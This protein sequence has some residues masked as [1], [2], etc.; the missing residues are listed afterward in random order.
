MEKFAHD[1]DDGLEGFFAVIAQSLGERVEVGVEALGGERGHI[2]GF[3]QAPVSLFGDARCAVDGGAGSDL[4]DIETGGGDPLSL[5]HVVG[6]GGEFGEDEQGAA[7]GD[8]GDRDEQA[9]APREFVIGG[10]DLE[11]GGL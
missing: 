4:S 5:G 6:P 1:G 9:Q 8:A 7:L 10:G 3:A 2:E 11:G